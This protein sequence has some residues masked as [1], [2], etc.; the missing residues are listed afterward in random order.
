MRAKLLEIDEK[1]T[2]ILLNTLK[3]D[4]EFTKF[5]HNPFLRYH[6]TMPKCIMRDDRESGKFDVS[7]II[8]L[9]FDDASHDA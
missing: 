8:C 6:V 5:L 2:A 7:A 1:Y 9:T 4:H 3:S